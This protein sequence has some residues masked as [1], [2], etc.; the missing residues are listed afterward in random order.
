MNCWNWVE[1]FRQKKE[2]NVISYS[3]APWK[4]F[5]FNFCQRHSAFLYSCLHFVATKRSNGKWFHVF[6]SPTTMSFF[7]SC[8]SDG[9]IE[10]R[11]KCW[12][13][14]LFWLNQSPS[15]RKTR[16]TLFIIL[17]DYRVELR[18]LPMKGHAFICII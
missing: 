10:I 3:G 15:D 4:T 8:F 2:T 17:I 7:H 13:S 11:E 1:N 6:P 5:F 18:L 16:R 9:L 12:L 14:L